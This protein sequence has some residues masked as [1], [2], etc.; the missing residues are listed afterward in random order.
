MLCAL[1]CPALPCPALPCKLVLQRRHVAALLPEMLHS[2][3]SCS[4]EHNIQMLY[5]AYAGWNS[6]ARRWQVPTC[7]SLLLTTCSSLSPPALVVLH[8]ARSAQDPCHAWGTSLSLSCSAAS[9]RHSMLSLTNPMVFEAAADMQRQ[10]QILPVLTQ[11]I[12]DVI[13]L[14]L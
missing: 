9:P 3:S 14:K 10:F 5:L 1:P 6:S 8:T 12:Q 11:T 4:L 13:E 2:Q 7:P